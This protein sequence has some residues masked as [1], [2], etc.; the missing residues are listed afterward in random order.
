LRGFYGPTDESTARRTLETA[1]DSGVTLFDAADMYG[2][3]D[4]ER[5]LAP[6]VAAHRGTIVLATKFG[7]MRS[8]DGSMP[9]RDDAAYVHQAV[10]ASLD[11][12]GID[13]IDLYYM[14]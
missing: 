1:L 7:D 9:T 14:H 13:V 8:S 6:F 4:N 5:F 3:G 11:R 12:L 2:Q 10:D